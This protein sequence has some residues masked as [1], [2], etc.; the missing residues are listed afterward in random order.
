M[1]RNSL[2]S[3]SRKKFLYNDGHNAAFFDVHQLKSI[4]G[5]SESHAYRIIKNPRLLTKKNRL[6][7]EILHFK[8][9]PGFPPGYSFYDGCIVDP[10]GFSFNF[11]DLENLKWLKSHNLSKAADKHRRVICNSKLINNDEVF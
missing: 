6:L 7:I 3:V 11:R 9:L 1:A 5:C 10:D 2:R 8:Q 4:L